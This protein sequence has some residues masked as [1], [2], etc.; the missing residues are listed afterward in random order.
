VDTE[1]IERLAYKI[2]EAA[3][4]KCDEST[5]DIWDYANCLNDYV[6]HGI[7]ALAEELCISNELSKEECETFKNLDYKELRE[8]ERYLKYYI[9]WHIAYRFSRYFGE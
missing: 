5:Q 6:D 4:Y 9:D 7:E 3:E 8:L 2:K 1:K